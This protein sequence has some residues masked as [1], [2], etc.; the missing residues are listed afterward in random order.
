M[1]EWFRCVNPP[2]VCPFRQIVGCH[3]MTAPPTVNW[4][5]LPCIIGN[6]TSSQIPSVKCPQT[7]YHEFGVSAPVLNCSWKVKQAVLVV[8]ICANAAKQPNTW[9][10]HRGHGDN[11]ISQPKSIKRTYLDTFHQ[12][13]SG[14]SVSEPQ[15]YVPSGRLSC[16]TIWWC[17]QQ[18][19]KVSCHT[20]LK[21]AQ[22]HC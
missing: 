1:L 18:W 8:R 21:M 15:W 4:G 19:M 3:K 13:W 20:S 10:I 7:M 22:I 5:I 11:G 16:V 12:C 14:S 17:C 6:G 2:V 9:H